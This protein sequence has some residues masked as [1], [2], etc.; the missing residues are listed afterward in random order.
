MK[1]GKPIALIKCGAC[2]AAIGLLLIAC[3]ALS[4]I[5]KSVNAN[6]PPRKGCVSVS[7]GEYDGAKRQKLLRNRYGSYVRTGR[8]WQHHYWYCR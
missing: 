4:V 5:A 8:V 1:R 7:K 3:P 6:Q 2:T